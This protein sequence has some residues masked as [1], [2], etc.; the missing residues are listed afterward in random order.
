M[1]Y[2]ALSIPRR[3][4]RLL[5]LFRPSPSLAQVECEVHVVS[6]QDS[7]RY[8]AL[9]YVWGDPQ[10]TEPIKVNGHQVQVTLNLA[11]AL[12]QPRHAFDTVELWV[13]TLCINQNE[14][15]EKNHQLPLMGEIYSKTSQII[16]WLGP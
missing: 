3:E 13:D 10:L 12:E 11:Y 7:P 2:T 15:I 1:E 14:V 5:T 9:F 6:L 16:V 8:D 4:I